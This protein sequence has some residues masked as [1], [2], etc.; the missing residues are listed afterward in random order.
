MQS[1]DT[2]AARLINIAHSLKDDVARELARLRASDLSAYQKRIDE[3]Q[4]DKNIAVRHRSSGWKYVTSPEHFVRR[5]RDELDFL[6]RANVF[7][8][9]G[10]GPGFL[11]A[12]LRECRGKRV[13]AID[14]EMNERFY[15]RRLREAIGVQSLVSEHA[16]KAYQSIPI[17]NGAE[18]V[19]AFGTG[20][21]RDW[22]IEEHMWFLGECRAKLT[23]PRLLFWRFLHTNEA[24]DAYYR[25]NARF[26]DK[27]KKTFCVVELD[28]VTLR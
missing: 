17:P 3:L 8:E 12:L 16:V 9:I 7:F 15:F 4:H 10:P 19:I 13:T 21:E 2:V 27:S 23:G 28:R 14:A 6:E 18:A 22:G 24:A 26:P 11:M 5:A 20:I 1:E 25:S